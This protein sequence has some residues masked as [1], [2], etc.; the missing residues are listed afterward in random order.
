MGY[1]IL[2]CLSRSSDSQT[3][4][5]CIVTW[6]VQWARVYNLAYPTSQFFCHV[7]LCT[8]VAYPP[9]LL[10]NLEFVLTCDTVS[11]PKHA[12]SHLYTLGVQAF[13]LSER[14]LTPEDSP[15]LNFRPPVPS[16]LHRLVWQWVSASKR[17]GSE[18]MLSS[19]WL[20]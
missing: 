10:A 15:S 20:S 7:I 13:A 4:Q 17:T 16:S 18:V 11:N 5:L 1:R 14:V 9:S 12:P 3:W 6:R 2:S 8:R 19:S